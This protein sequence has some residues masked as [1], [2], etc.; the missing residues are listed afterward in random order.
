MEM[1]LKLK[2][3]ADIVRPGAADGQTGQKTLQRVAP[4]P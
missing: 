4:L 3:V 2:S 1:K